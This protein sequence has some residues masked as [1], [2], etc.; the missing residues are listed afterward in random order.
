MRRA[1]IGLAGV[2]LLAASPPRAEGPPRARKVLAPT[3]FPGWQTHNVSFPFVVR[4]G[5]TGSWRMYYT[6]SA[7]DQRSGSAWDLW[8]TG[9]VRSPDLVRWRYPDDYEPVL[10]GRRFLEGDLVDHDGRVPAFDAIMAAS[11]WVMKDGAQWRAWYTGWNGDERPRGGGRVEQVHFRIGHATSPDGLR[12]TK[13]RGTAEGG[14]SIG[15]GAPGEADALA[16]AH[17]AVVKVGVA[18][19]LWYEAYD[20]AL[21]RIARAHSTDGM[22]WVKDGAAL[23]PGRGDAPDA[24]GARDP[25]VRKTAAGYELWY[26]GQSPGAPTFH[27]LRATSADGA[28]WTKQPGEVVLHPDPPL[29]GEEGIHVGSVLAQPDGSS[30]V[31]FAKETAVPR[32]AAWGTV[33]DRT[34]AIYSEAMRP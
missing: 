25:V 23:E 22:A 10:T 27:V 26:Q 9:V 33:V 11:A 32:R 8:A 3:G 5:A 14:A 4:D 1:L 13:V 17:P 24:L 2:A 16:V 12:W 29:G 6:G 20:G 34:T 21:W 15:L 18:Y 31:F 28:R 19:H 7:T 30:L